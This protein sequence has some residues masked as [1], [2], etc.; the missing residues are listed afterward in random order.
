MITSFFKPSAKK[1]KTHDGTAAAAPGQAGEPGD[2]AAAPAAPD[3]AVVAK[4]AASKKAARLTVARK[5]LSGLSDE[6]WRGALEA[7]VSKDYFYDLAQFVA[8]ER[9][10][11]AVYPPQD[12]VFA[13]L[14]ACPLA[15]VK[16][17]IIGQDPYHGAGQANGLAFSIADDAVCKFPP[18]L[19]NIFKEV[20][21]CGH[22][23]PRA[24]A[25]DLAPWAKQG[26]L[27][28]NTCLTVRGAAANSHQKQGWERVTDSLVKAVNRRE[29]RGAVFLL[30]GKPAQAKCA[31]IDRK[32]HRVLQSSHPSPLSNGKTAEPFTGSRC[33]AKANELLTGALGHEE[34][35]KWDL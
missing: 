22:A 33:F 26:V 13:A 2:G 31:A 25:G 32:S 8:G 16:V 9:R 35:I 10:K 23:L 11:G 18:S 27:L 34:G 20:A 21:D 19:R 4:I 17:V 24:G 1:Q 3:A 30:W 29:G 6:G 14:N 28:L 15:D 7:E 5:L 12:Q